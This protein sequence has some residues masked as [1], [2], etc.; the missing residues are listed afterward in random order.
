MA[1]APP[2]NF[3]PMPGDAAGGAEGP[4]G[5]PP[6]PIED[7]FGG[8]AGDFGAGG[9]LFRGGPPPDASPGGAGAAAT[10]GTQGAPPPEA[11][12]IL[13]LLVVAEVMDFMTSIQAY[14]AGQPVEANTDF[15]DFLWSSFGSF[16]VGALGPT[17]VAA[18]QAFEAAKSAQAFG[19]GLTALGNEVIAAGEQA[20]PQLDAVQAYGEA[21]RLLIELAGTPAG[22]GIQV[23]VARDPNQTAPILPNPLDPTPIPLNER[24]VVD[25]ES[26]TQFVTADLNRLSIFLDGSRTVTDMGTKAVLAKGSSIDTAPLQDAVTLSHAAGALLPSGEGSA[27][28]LPGGHWAQFDPVTNGVIKIS[29]RADQAVPPE[30]VAAL[31]SSTDTG[32]API[33]EVGQGFRSIPAPPPAP[34]AAPRAAAGGT[35]TLLSQLASVPLPVG[36]DPSTGGTPD[37]LAPAPPPPPG[38]AG[39]PAGPP[40]AAEQFAVGYGKAVLADWIAHVANPFTAS[41]VIDGILAGAETGVRIAEQA[42]RYHAKGHYGIT[43]LFLAANKV[44]NESFNPLVQIAMSLQATI[45]EPDYEKKGEKA[46]GATR[47]IL[48]AVAAAVD[49]ALGPEGGATAAEGAGAEGGADF[50]SKAKFD[51]HFAKHGGEWPG[52]ISEADYLA[53]ARQ[54]LSE[55]VGGDIL[56]YERPGPGGNDIL[57]YNTATNEFAVQAPDGSIRTLF[58]PKDGIN[59]W[60]KQVGK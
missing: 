51:Q 35:P 45:D 7:V 20:V 21:L 23:D 4:E 26:V 33:G 37:P 15:A 50:A 40:P 8:G 48:A 34:G 46:F 38:D 11:P 55:P 60:N 29:A 19:S 53:K 1:E 9:G 32:Y 39:P 12:V 13:P 54:L 28:L 44:L 47:A 10:L 14:Q 59:Y 16:D 30:A 42:Y 41:P 18:F 2:G 57:R 6:P 49:A 5:A 3:E 56:G 52:G 24:F 58:R 17:D 25:A 27:V 36:P 22:G 31:A 43:S